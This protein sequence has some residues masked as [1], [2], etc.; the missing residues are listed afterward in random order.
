MT[1]AQ[2][3][4]AGFLPSPFVIPLS[5]T[6]T[7][8]RN[9]STTQG[10]CNGRLLYSACS[11]EELKH[12]IALLLL[13]GNECVLFWFNLGK[14]TEGGTGRNSLF[15]QLPGVVFR[16]SPPCLRRH[17]LHPCK[18][19]AGSC[20]QAAPRRGCHHHPGMWQDQRDTGEEAEWGWCRCAHPVISGTCS[21]LPD[22]IAE[23]GGVFPGPLSWEVWCW[24]VFSNAYRRGMTH[25][26]TWGLLWLGIKG[27]LALSSTSKKIWCLSFLKDL[28]CDTFKVSMYLPA[29]TGPHSESKKAEK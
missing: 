27:F 11:F 21:W 24:P 19:K 3:D 23:G 20:P 7:E 1:V 4:L 28:R 10:V 17:H 12:R 6:H 18:R 22:T 9:F 16:G 2:D 14:A 13:E 5:E 15:C 25:R 8:A 29:G 26:R